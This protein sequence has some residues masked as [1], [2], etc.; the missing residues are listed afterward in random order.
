MQLL[1]EMSINFQDDKKQQTSAD[2]HEITVNTRIDCDTRQEGNNNSPLVRVLSSKKQ[3]DVNAAG[4]NGQKNN[5]FARNVQSQNQK[6]RVSSKYN[7]LV[8]GNL[9]VGSQGLT[10]KQASSVFFKEEDMQL[11]FEKAE[12]PVQQVIEKILLDDLDRY[13]GFTYTAK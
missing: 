12:P 9:V 2:K 10:S 5:N 3:N 11:L 7:E 13:Q 1:P 6:Y 8:G 4:K